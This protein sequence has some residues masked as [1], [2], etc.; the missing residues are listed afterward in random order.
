[1][2]DPL[3]RINCSERTKDLEYLKDILRNNCQIIMGSIK[4]IVECTVTMTD[5]LNAFEEK[6][7]KEVR[8][9]VTENGGVGKMPE[10][11]N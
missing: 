1:M 6:W 7:G 9:H 8:Q 11:G 10:K 5:A 3:E 4:R 2:I